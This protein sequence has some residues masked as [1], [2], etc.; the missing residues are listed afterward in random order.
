MILIADNY[1]KNNKFQKCEIELM[2]HPKFISCLNFISFYESL[3]NFVPD[4]PLHISW[5]E[6]DY[7][8]IIQ[9]WFENIY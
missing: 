3:S 9:K 8:K 6:I 2:L 4:R 7:V 5:C 1:V